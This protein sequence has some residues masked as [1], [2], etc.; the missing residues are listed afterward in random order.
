[1]CHTCNTAGMI[2]SMSPAHTQPARF[3]N[4]RTKMITT[5]SDIFSRLLLTVYNQNICT[6]TICV[7]STLALSQMPHH[8]LTDFEKT[9]TKTKKV[10][11]SNMLMLE[12][13]IHQTWFLQVLDNIQRTHKKDKKVNRKW[14]DQDPENH[15][16]TSHNVL[17][18]FLNVVF[19]N[20]C[21]MCTSPYFY[22]L[23]SFSLPLL[24]G[25]WAR[26]P[27]GQYV[28]FTVLPIAEG[29]PGRIRLSL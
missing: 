8:H 12:K 22:V 9:K 29:L 6:D 15:C 24:Q 28:K 11:I 25:L 26:P 19:Q 14:N 20:K 17:S 27:A 23:F 7:I 16:C 5:N 18:V 3:S 13:K 2:V 1:M 10:F 21:Q 4:P